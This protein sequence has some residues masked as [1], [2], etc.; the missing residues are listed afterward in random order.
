MHYLVNGGGQQNF[1][2]TNNGGTWEK[3]VGSLFNGAVL[4]YWFTYEKGGPLF[5]SAHFQ[6][7]HGGVN[8]PPPPPPPG[9][10]PPP[11]PPGPQPG[12]L[13]LNR[14]ATGSAS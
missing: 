12:N 13:A 5:D 11:P 8:P 4:D 10:Q 9:P 6:Y 7:V 14:P 3:T 1:R 2:M